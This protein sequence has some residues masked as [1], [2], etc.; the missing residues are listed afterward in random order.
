MEMKLFLTASFICAGAFAMADGQKPVKAAVISASGVYKDYKAENCVDGVVSDDSRWIGTPDASGSIWVELTLAAKQRLAGV[1]I[2]SGYRNDDAVSDLRLQFRGADGGWTDIPSAAVVNNRKT[3]FA[4]EFDDTIEVETDALRLLITKTKGD[5][6]RLRE[7]VVWPD[8]GGKIPPAGTAV[9]ADPGAIEP[10]AR[11][12]YLNQSGFNIGR[13]KRFTAPALPDG[14]PFAVISQRTSAEVFQGVVNQHIGDFSAFDS[15]SGDEYVI[16]AGELQSYPFGIG[17]WWL[18]R[19]T[20][21]NAMDFM[22]ESRHLVGNYRKPCRGSFGWRDDHHFGW[23]L[24]TLVPQYLSN[25][26]AYER[27]PRKVSYEASPG[28]IGALQP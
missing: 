11:P 23:E 21:Q 7:V 24:N 10:E 15:D 25:P 16:R 9:H 6:A 19:V 14:T 8:T 2:Y 12:I 4:L 13:P 1:H 22:I 5:M 26:A 27:M 20:Y 18:E 28:F 17:H 3:A